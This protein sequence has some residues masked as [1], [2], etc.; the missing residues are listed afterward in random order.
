MGLRDLFSFGGRA[1]QAA[2]SRV[3]SEGVAINIQDLDDPALEQLLRGG[4][5]ASSGAVVNMT[6]TMG[7]S[8]AWRSTLLLAGICGNFPID[9]FKR[10]SE[11][12]R[13]AAS[14]HSLREVLT[15]RPNGWQTPSTFRKMMT[16]H[17]VNKGDAFALK[18][19]SLGRVIELWPLDDPERMQVVQNDDMTLSYTFTTRKGRVVKLAQDEVF[20]LR[21]FSID[22]IRG[23]GV[24]KAAREALGLSMTMQAAGGRMFKNGVLA[25]GAVKLPAGKSL[26]DEAYERLKADLDANNAGPENAG[27]LLILEDGLDYATGMFSAADMQFLEGR[28]FSRTDIAMFYGVPPFLLGDTEK[29]TSWGTG[30]EQQNTGF[31]QYTGLDL[32]V[33]WEEACKQQLL[34]K[35]DRKAGFFIKI[36]PRILLRGDQKTRSEGYARALGSGGGVPWMT[37]NEVRALEDLPPITGGDVLPARSTAPPPTTPPKDKTDDGKRPDDQA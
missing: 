12:A 18:I 15:E 34:S 6:S 29:S 21:G 24:L 13:L 31:I 19:T 8:T 3:R 11:T 4:S 17:V 33:M 22:G 9:V 30:L 5:V 10:V 35:A 1:A 26:S 2:P 36:D 27:K 32:H 37:V 23:I 7:I 25:G 14:D 20:H 28:R 16:A